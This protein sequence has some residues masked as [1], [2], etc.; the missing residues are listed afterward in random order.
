MSDLVIIEKELSY[1]IMQA[2]FEVYNELR[3]GFPESIYDAAMSRE[4]TRQGIRLERQR[5]L[6]YISKGRKS[7]SLFWIV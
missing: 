2:A 4:L 5:R 6:M 1:L 3:P 7:V